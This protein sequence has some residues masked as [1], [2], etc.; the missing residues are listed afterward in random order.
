MKWGLS[1]THRAWG[2]LQRLDKKTARKIVKKLRYF[3]EQPKPLRHSK[4]LKGLYKGLFRFR[5]ADYRAIFSK[6]ARGNMTMV[7]IIRVGHR[8]NIYE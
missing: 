8:K 1:Y 4:A 5:I 7:T 6:D 2:D 3:V